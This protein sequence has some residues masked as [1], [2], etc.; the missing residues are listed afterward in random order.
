MQLPQL[1]YFVAVAEN[2]HF[3][4][5]AEDV[6]VSQPALSKQIRGL[7]RELGAQLFSR[8]RGNVAVT[9][10]GE[11]LLPIAKRI[12]ADI[13][14]AR[15]Q[16][17]ELVDLRRGRVRLGATPSLSTV[18][19][20]DILARYHDAYPGI[21]LL[22]EESGS[23]HLLPLLEQGELDVALVILPLPRGHPALSSTPILRE[24][25]VVAAPADGSLVRSRSL[26][27]R[28][29]QNYPLVMFREGYDLR[30]ATLAAFRSARIEPRYAVEGG[31]MDAVLRFVE[32]GLGLAIVPSMAL[33]GRP[34]LRRVPFV[35]PGLSRTVALAHRH[36]VDPPI[37]AR[38]FQEMLLDQLAEA[39]RSGKLPPGTEPVG[40]K[41]R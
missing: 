32:A 3:T 20:P 21:E 2:L 11:A 5:A 16:V 27:I 26:S 17:Q 8:A 10:A 38:V 25:L 31:E 13:E 33:L 24:P 7:E 34:G 40:K 14:N 18:L 6:H 28:D 23:R 9:S 22:V 29:L 12:L 41:R 19:L 30:D 37:A 15:L 4:R 35:K 1:A 36:D 39:A